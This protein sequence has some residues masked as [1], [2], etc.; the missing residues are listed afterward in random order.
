M[1]VFSKEELAMLQDA[2]LNDLAMQSKDNIR[3]I[4]F[5][6]DLQSLVLAMLKYQ[7][8]HSD[9]E[10]YDEQSISLESFH[11]YLTITGSRAMVLNGKK[12]LTPMPDFTNYSPRPAENDDR[13]I[14][15]QSYSFNL[16]HYFT[17]YDG[18]KKGSM[19]IRADRSTSRGMQ[20]FEDYGENDNSLYIEMFGF[21]PQE[22]PFNC[23]ILDLNR[24][25]S[26][27]II[28][29][30]DRLNLVQVDSSI[31]KVKSWPSACVLEDGT[32][33]HPYAEKFFAV[34]SLAD[35]KSQQ[36]QCEDAIK[37]QDS[38]YITIS[39]FRYSGFKEKVKTSINDAA[40]YTL[41]LKPT[42]LISDLEYL[43]SAS[44]L[45]QNSVTALLFRIREKGILS[46]I[47]NGE[48]EYDDNSDKTCQ[49]EMSNLYESSP[50][51]ELALVENV[52]D[53]NLFLENNLDLV[54]NYLRASFIGNGMRIGAITTKSLNKGDTYFSFKDGYDISAVTAIEDTSNSAA[55][56]DLLDV[57]NSNEDTFHVLL[58]YL[59]AQMFVL[60]ERSKWWSY[61]KLLPTPTELK[62]SSP[63]WFDDKTLDFLSGSD[64]RPE[65]LS[66]QTQVSNKF[67][68]MMSQPTVV[69]ALGPVFMRENYIWA[70]SIIDTRAI[71]Y[72]GLRHLVPMLDL[73][74]C[75]SVSNFF[76]FEYKSDKLTVYLHFPIKKPSTI[77][78]TERGTGGHIETKAA[79]DFGE[80]DQILENYGQ[81]NYIYMLYHGFTLND[82]EY[83]CALFRSVR[84]DI[85]NENDE[86][87][88]QVKKSL[89]SEGFRSLNPT[90]CIKD[91]ESLSRMER[92]LQIKYSKD[93]V[94][95]ELKEI[96]QG[97]LVRI[98][99]AFQQ[100]SIDDNCMSS[101]SQQMRDYVKNEGIIIL[102]LLRNL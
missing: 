86:T 89:F 81:P 35:N 70:H 32:L 84:I 27:T 40:K 95:H 48:T 14:G 17:N 51:E 73:I 64:L 68:Y 59:M 77:H 6:N 56:K 93:D 1:D 37:S 44:S 29:L 55:L 87:F 11:K 62:L 54:S 99:T 82:N 42:S 10:D 78:R 16:Y 88:G 15:E 69:R 65:I 18:N 79:I 19:I 5:S 85:K 58:F 12:Y 47:L 94:D 49:V 50:K 31:R 13:K 102:E 39:C 83:D 7:N 75:S 90:F 52:H 91:R 20:V 34:A 53:F 4:W 23:A 67:N 21:I 57:F 9:L 8:Q 22:N 63:L 101:K 43:H 30:F 2:Q 76:T 92:F 61:L 72:D 74:N 45:T 46:K 33:S 60:K 28:A 41:N 97:R 24:Y 26:E 71:W 38:E 3:R 25:Y 36:Q 80:G 100:V 66:Y 96:L 98:D